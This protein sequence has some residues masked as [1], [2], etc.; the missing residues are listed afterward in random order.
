MRCRFHDASVDDRFPRGDPDMN[1][2]RE[3]I[4]AIAGKVSPEVTPLHCRERDLTPNLCTAD[5][6]YDGAVGAR[7][8]S[9]DKDL[10]GVC[11]GNIQRTSDG[12]AAAAGTLAHEPGLSVR[13][14]WYKIGC[15]TLF[16]NRF[17]PRGRVCSS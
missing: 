10:R 4:R 6:L 16:A 3:V 11:A 12:D 8:C 13:N 7:Q 2:L 17:R 1:D 15:R 14:I 5:R 9:G